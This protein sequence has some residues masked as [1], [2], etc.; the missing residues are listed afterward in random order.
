MSNL[1][2][3]YK[4]IFNTNSSSSGSSSPTL[5][6]SYIGY[7]SGTNILTGSSDLTFDS[8]NSRLMVGV[9][10]PGYTLDVNGAIRIRTSPNL[11]WAELSTG[12]TLNWEIYGNSGEIRFYN[13]STAKEVVIAQGKIG[14]QISPTA[15]INI[16]PGTAT[17]GTSPLKFTA[18]TNL[19]TPENGVV[20]YDGTNLFFTRTGTIRENLLS[21]VESTLNALGLTAITQLV[22]QIKVNINGVSYYIPCSAANT[23]LT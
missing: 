13:Y 5:T 16:G 4:K 8:A 1:V 3:N 17:A 2:K 9:G 19:T 18:G 11:V 6:N 21:G 12:T 20:E 22:N 14:L 7:G 23:T 10:T 15:W